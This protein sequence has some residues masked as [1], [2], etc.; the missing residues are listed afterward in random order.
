MRLVGV[1]GLLL[2]SKD[3]CTGS[4]PPEGLEAACMSDRLVW[5]GLCFSLHQQRDRAQSTDTLQSR[6]CSSS[7]SHWSQLPVDVV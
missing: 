3:A 1:H 5:K 2:L 6:Q 4:W 7:S